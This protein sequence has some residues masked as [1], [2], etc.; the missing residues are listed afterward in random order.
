MI[1]NGDK[2]HSGAKISQTLVD[3]VHLLGSVRAMVI[4]TAPTER[5]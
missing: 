4:E 5:Y 1:I 3:V 2:V